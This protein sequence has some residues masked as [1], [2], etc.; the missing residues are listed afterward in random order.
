MNRSKR[1]GQLT[2]AVFTTLCFCF[3]S[4]WER[5]EVRANLSCFPRPS[6]FPLPEGE[7]GIDSTLLVQ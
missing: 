5:T 4:L 1:F 2:L 7:G 6:P 3:L